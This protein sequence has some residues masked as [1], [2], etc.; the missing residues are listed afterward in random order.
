MEKEVKSGSQAESEQH[1]A[2]QVHSAGFCSGGADLERSNLM[3]VMMV[4]LTS[5]SHPSSQF[6]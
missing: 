3:M 6:Q 5:S 1:D 2:S 4:Y